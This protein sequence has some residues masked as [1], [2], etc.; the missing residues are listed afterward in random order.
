MQITKDNTVRPQ[1]SYQKVKSLRSRN[2]FSLISPLIS[3]KCNLKKHLLVKMQIQLIFISMRIPYLK[4]V[5]KYGITQRVKNLVKLSL[6]F[7]LFLMYS[8]NFPRNYQRIPVRAEKTIFTGLD[9]LVG[10]GEPLGQPVVGSPPAS[11]HHHTTA[12]HPQDIPQQFSP[13]CKFKH[14]HD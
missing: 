12:T 14:F 11:Q 10:P 1:V 8:Y 4:Y 2:L 9:D 7:I 5:Q 3:Q 13:F 6:S